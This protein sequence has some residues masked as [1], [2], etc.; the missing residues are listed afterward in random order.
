[1]NMPS[2]LAQP[3]LVL[4]ESWAAI[5]TVTVRHALRLMFT[6][7]AKAVAPQ[8]Y[9]VHGFESWAE[10]SVQPHEAC[11]ST[12]RLRIKAPE[13]IVLTR[14]NGMPNP[15]AVFSR[16]NLFRRDHNQCQY[17]GIRPGTAELSIDHVFPRSRGGKSSWENC[18]LACMDCNRRKRDRTP[19]EAGIK[20]LKKP[21]K[22][23]WS[24]VL[25]V[26]VGRVKRSWE[27]FVSD[28]YW[29]VKLEE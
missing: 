21:E 26:P 1:M 7:A 22:P 17:C 6:G 10:L 25:E 24:P 3:A 29:N 18:V 5:H 16:R 9:E 13:V 8:T 11:I 15:A 28:A 4:N 27:R 19:E 2:V 14:Y 23:R 12:V 20:L